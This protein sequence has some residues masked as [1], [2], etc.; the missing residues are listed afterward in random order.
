MTKYEES[1][2]AVTTPV[3][4]QMGTSGAY[5]DPDLEK[6]TLRKF[7][8]SVLPQFMLLVLIAYL[9]RSNIGSW[10]SWHCLGAAD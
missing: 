5:I 8:K 7:D 3:D 4:R 10:Q 2:H 9:D 6:R 1:K